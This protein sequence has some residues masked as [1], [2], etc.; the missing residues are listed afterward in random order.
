M[1]TTTA[2]G[3]PALFHDPRTRT[4]IEEIDRI[5][6]IIILGNL[7]RLREAI[8]FTE[9]SCTHMDGLGGPPKCREGEE[10]GTPVEVL[11]FLGPEGN[12]LRKDE[13]Q[14]WPGIEVNGLYAVYRVS[15]EVYSDE[16]Y[17][18]GEYGI[19]FVAGDDYVYGVVLQVSDG[20]I[21]R[22]DYVYGEPLEMKL[23]GEAEEI[24]LPAP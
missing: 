13:V 23:G 20:A 9:T 14:D 15:E 3:T 21:V 12:F 19:A 7:D 2:T 10:E 18:A 17:P 22:V 8:A 11:P 24:I 1:P 16:N 5:I 4:G 6:D